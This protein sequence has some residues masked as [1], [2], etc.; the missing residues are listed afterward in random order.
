MIQ[1]FWSD[2]SG[3]TAIE[4]GLIAAGIAL[5]IITVVNGLGTAMNE[6]FTSISTSLK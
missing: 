4:Y 2:E 6:K 3:A 1:K 5:A